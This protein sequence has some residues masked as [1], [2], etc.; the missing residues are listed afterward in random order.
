MAPLM[1]LF[2]RILELTS[3]SPL[4]PRNTPPNSNNGNIIIDLATKNILARDAA[5]ATK[6]P[7]TILATSP[8]ETNAGQRAKLDITTYTQPHCQG[9]SYAYTDWFY[10]TDTTI[11]AGAPGPNGA[12]SFKLSRPLAKGEQLDF[13]GKP[14]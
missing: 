7:T 9:T 5:A 6:T 4:L 13:S 1:A 2:V 3:L 11:T 12:H 10:S 8:Q 14:P